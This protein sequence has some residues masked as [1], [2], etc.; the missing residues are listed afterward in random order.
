MEGI[1]WVRR[2]TSPKYQYRGAGKEKNYRQIKGQAWSAV[3]KA[4]TGKSVLFA[5]KVRARLP[6]CL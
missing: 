6:I 1:Y 5:C 4:E 2:L 3:Q